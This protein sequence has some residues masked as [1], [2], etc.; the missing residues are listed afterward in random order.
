MKRAVAILT[1]VVLAALT[2]SGCDLLFGPTGGQDYQLTFNGN[3]HTSGTVPSGGRFSAGTTTYLAA[4]GSMLRSGYTFDG[5][6]TEQNGTGDNYQAGAPFIMP[7]RAVTL[8]AKW[9]ADMVSIIFHA[10][11]GSDPEALETQNVIAGQAVFLQANTFIRSGY[12]FM[13]W[14]TS[15]AGALAY[16]NGVQYLMGSS[17]VHLY[18]V[19]Y[20]TG[21]V[22]EY[23]V[24]FNENGGTGTMD[25]QSITEG[26][27]ETLTLNTFTRTGYRF[28]GWAP[29]STATT[30]TYP[31][32]GSYT[33]ANANATLYAVWELISSEL[34]EFTVTFNANGGTGTMASQVF[35]EGE[36]EQLASNLFQKTGS[37][38]LYWALVASSTTKAYD[39]GATIIL[40]GNLVLY[41][42][43]QDLSA[44]Q[45]TVTFN[46]NDGSG[47]TS[48]QLID[49]GV[50]TALTANT[51]TRTGYSFLGWTTV[52]SSSTVVYT[53]GATVTRTSNLALYAVW[54]ILPS[55]AQQD[56]DAGVALLKLD[57]PDF[58]SAR[59]MFLSAVTKDPTYA[60]ALM[61]SSLLNLAAISV[62]TSMVSMMGTYFGVSGYPTTMN[63]LFTSN[64][65]MM[66]VEGGYWEEGYWDQDWIDGY[67]VEGHYEDGYWE[68]HWE[69]V[70]DEND[71]LIDS[72]WV[73]DNW[74]AEPYWVDEYYVDGYWDSNW[75]DDV[76]IDEIWTFPTIAIPEAIK[77]YHEGV[78]G[79]TTMDEWRDSLIFNIATNNSTGFNALADAVTTLLD[80]GLSGVLSALEG[81]SGDA[82]IAI[83]ASLLGMGE[84][85]VIG[86]AE[87]QL[88]TAALYGLKSSIHMGKSISLSLP[89]QDYYAAFNPI[90]N[91]ELY[92]DELDPESHFNYEAFMAQLA[93][94]DTPFES[95]FLMPRA[96]A[97]TALDLAKTATLA[98]LDNIGSAMTAVSSRLSTAPFTVRPGSFLFDEP[99]YEPD[100]TDEVKPSMQF[101]RNLA[102]RMHAAISD[103]TLVFLP[104]GSPESYPESPMDYIREFANDANWPT[105][106][107]LGIPANWAGTEVLPGSDFPTAIGLRPAAAFETPLFA[108]SNL[109]DMDL[110]TGEPKFY[111]VDIDENDIITGF[112]GTAATALTVQG[113]PE[114]LYA[115]RI[116]DLTFNTSLA[117]TEPEYTAVKAALVAAMLNVGM[118]ENFD[119]DVLMTRSPT[120]GA[121]SL[122]VPLVPGDIAEGSFLGDSFWWALPDLVMS[123][124]MPP[125]EEKPQ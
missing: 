6:N 92:T 48:T 20:A 71:N 94:L 4:Q 115:L 29:T 114:I 109:L 53:N 26:I 108:I 13:G 100:W 40:N 62:D 28:K 24:T 67:W 38:F 37:E 70:Y 72:Y 124:M 104:V 27:S 121:V 55:E 90:D 42:V 8:Y 113:A 76:W 22:T 50:S 18:A 79:V 7:N 119:L 45:Y 99:G 9:V 44:E 56:V 34:Q 35:T 112:D 86:K 101:T 102:A 21:S 33:M 107:D 1:M 93:T 117:L 89:L 81:I 125:V 98:S 85:I 105:E 88:E 111:K 106:S 36:P 16:G 74:V 120:T 95:G 65:W 57:P 68:G 51:F 49:N 19:W 54:E 64:D 59:T 118:P 12:S 15:P 17:E 31:D 123:M 91:P 75:I 83:P 41:A 39:N 3:G 63:T 69:Y 61:W 78:E 14:A 30:A 116:R 122:F 87:L 52:P 47:T 10:N 2:M 110:D 80:D 66:E 58:N 82:T 5:W 103:N 96:D 84:D 43:W 46:K 73:N 77:T 97:A 25:V 32:G 60:P 23:T 11:D